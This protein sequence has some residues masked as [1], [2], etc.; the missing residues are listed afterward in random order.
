MPYHER[1]GESKLHPIKDGFRFLR[2]IM[3]T[4]LLYRPS[5]PLGLIATILFGITCVMMINP[6]Y[7]YLRHS[8]VEEWMMYRFL[9]GEL[10]RLDHR[11]IDRGGAAYR[12]QFARYRDRDHR[13]LGRFNGSNRRVRARIR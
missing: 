9:V 13:R 11:A 8:L 12:K 5:R 7:V 10:L 1:V 3:E 2:V 4:T 6:T